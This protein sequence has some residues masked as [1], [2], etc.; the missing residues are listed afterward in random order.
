[1]SAQAAFNAYMAEP[2]LRG[3]WL[4]RT[5]MHGAPWH[6]TVHPT[7]AA[8]FKA[9]HRPADHAQVFQGDYVLHRGGWVS[10]K[11]KEYLRLNLQD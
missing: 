7:K 6:D 9:A 3:A 1:M 10:A 5:K 4:V 8:A 2:L 11:G